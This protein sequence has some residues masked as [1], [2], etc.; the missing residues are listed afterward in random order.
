[1]KRMTPAQLRK[2]LEKAGLSQSGAAREI[3]IGDRTMRRYIAGD[4]PIPKV[5]EL[6]LLYV[7]SRKD[8]K[9]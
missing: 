7:I 9:P 1:M 6:A 4:L 8:V 2:L 5:V 3:D